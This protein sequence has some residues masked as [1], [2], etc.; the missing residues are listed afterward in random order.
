MKHI[1]LIRS[2]INGHYKIGITSNIRRRMRQLQTA[3]SSSL[4]LIDS[5]E[6][7]FPNKVE[8]TLHNLYSYCKLSGE[9]FD[10]SVKEIAEF[11]K[12]CGKIE[13]NYS[14]LK[15]SKDNI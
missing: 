3:Q 1:Y 10:L 7:K 12:L 13:N 9:W 14:F 5:F 8:T 6:S 11:N 4:T 2:D 15:H